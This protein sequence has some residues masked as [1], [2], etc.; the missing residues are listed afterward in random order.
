VHLKDLFK[1]Q[2]EGTDRN[3][4]SII[5]EVN[6]IPESKSISALLKLFKTEKSQIAVI[7]DEYGGTSGLVT[8]E[9][10]LEEIVG[11]IQD[12]FDEES[13]EIVKTE[14]GSYIVDGRVL[15]DTIMDLIDADIEVENIDTIGGWIYSQLKSYPKINDKFIYENYEFTVLKCDKNRISKVLIKKLSEK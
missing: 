6:F 15:L 1:N 12:E 14:D 7:I 5:R 11:E 4:E 9:D 3:I 10:I 8:V 13:N 2:V